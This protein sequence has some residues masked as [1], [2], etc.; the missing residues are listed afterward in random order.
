MCSFARY[1][2]V[3]VRSY[4]IL[5]ETAFLLGQI[6]IGKGSYLASESLKKAIL[7]YSMS[8]LILGR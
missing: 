6:G 3:T 1:L 8:D 5:T 2:L 4:F 7:L